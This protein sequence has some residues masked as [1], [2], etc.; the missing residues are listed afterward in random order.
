[1]KQMRSFRRSISF[2]AILISLC[3]IIS[4][5]AQIKKVNYAVIGL[6]NAEG[7]SAGEADIIADRLRIELFNTGAANMMERD[8]MQEILSEQGFQQS[9]ACTDEACMI[10]LGQ[11]LGVERLISGSIGKLGSMFLLNFRAIDVQTA[12]IIKVVSHDITGGI[13]DVVKYLP[14][15]ALQLT[16][17]KPKK[18][19]KPQEPEPTPEPEVVETPPEPEPEPEVVEKP[20]EPVPVPTPEEKPV[21][22]SAWKRKNK[23]KS[24]VRINFILFPGN[25]R[26]D[27][28]LHQGTSTNLSWSDWKEQFDYTNDKLFISPQIRAIIKAGSII[29]INIG[30]GYTRGEVEYYT[31]DTQSF[32]DH[33]HKLE[34]KHNIISIL[35]GVNLVFRFFPAKINVGFM[36]DGNIPITSYKATNMD[37][38]DQ[39]NY[40]FLEDME[41]RGTDVDFKVSAG[42]RVGIEFLLGTP[43][44][45]MGFEFLIRPLSFTY[46]RREISI[47]EEDLVIKDDISMPFIGLGVSISLYN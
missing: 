11:L 24:G 40:S 29:A 16:G 5:S 37:E 34:I 23:N 2:H 14:N 26:H 21:T 22:E 36:L 10:E 31:E 47:F 33:D 9:G 44:V 13:E 30:A 42:G 25:V 18:V 8:Q 46:E 28:E 4:L 45:G 39:W 12:R 6:K 15:I 3:M 43:R 32:F 17:E 38:A 1:M 35:T 41:G 7:V 20:P 19:A 27:V